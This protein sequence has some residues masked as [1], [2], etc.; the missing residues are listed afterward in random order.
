MRKLKLQKTVRKL[1]H[2]FRKLY[3][4]GTVIIFSPPQ[5]IENSRQYCFSERIFYRK[6]SLGAPGKFLLTWPLTFIG[7]EYVYFN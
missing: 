6:Q 3:M 5:I 4:N 1:L 7:T 2:K